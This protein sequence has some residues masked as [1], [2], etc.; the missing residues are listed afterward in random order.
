VS[1]FAHQ[2]LLLKAPF[3][4]AVVSWRVGSTNADKTKGM[5][6]AYV[7]ARDVMQRLD[8][9]VGPGHWQA[10]YVP[11]SNGTTCCRI[12][13]KCDGEWVWKSN[14]AGATDYEADKGAYSDAFKRAAVLWGI[15]RYLYDLKSPWVEVEAKGKSVFIKEHEKQR[16]AD[17]LAGNK[18]RSNYAAR[19]DGDDAAFK[20]IEQGLRAAA[21]HGGVAL[22]EYW[23]A[24][25]ATIKSW[26]AGW[27]AAITQEKDRLKAELSEDAAA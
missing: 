2:L 22:G 7:D 14:G 20:Q 5:A 4:P 15:A 13:I 19:K 16:L 25:Q 3:D 26:P 8:D 11:M 6:L 12:G 10:E 9:T 21:R 18:P 24:Q 23:K 17:L 27:R 1:D